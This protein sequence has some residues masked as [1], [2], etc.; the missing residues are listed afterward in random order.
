MTY[1]RF[2]AVTAQNTLIRRDPMQESYTSRSKPRLTGFILREVA[3]SAEPSDRFVPSSGY[4]E[5]APYTV[6]ATLTAPAV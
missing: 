4:L 6:P 1:P 5:G 3:N 2:G